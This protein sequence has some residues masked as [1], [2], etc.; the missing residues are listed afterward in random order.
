M[1]FIQKGKVYSRKMQATE[2]SVV[3]NT[4]PKC[5]YHELLIPMLIPGMF[6]SH[7]IL[8]TDLVVEKQR[9]VLLEKQIQWE[10][11]EC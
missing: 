7:C 9:V 6:K 5:I 11:K 3:N 4:N 8:L 10:A 1:Y 2:F